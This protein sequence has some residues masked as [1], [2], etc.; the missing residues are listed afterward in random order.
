MRHQAPRPKHRPALQALAALL[1]RWLGFVLFWFARREALPTHEQLSEYEAELKKLI[2]ARAF[3]IFPKLTF[4]AQC[5]RDGSRPLAGFYKQMTR[6]LLPK[7][8]RR[9]RAARAARLHRVLDRVDVY[10]AKLAARLARGLMVMRVRRRIVRTHAPILNAD[11]RAPTPAD[12][13]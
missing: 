3:E 8:Q 9:T 7:L 4:R 5:V 2:F 11:P 10:V 1:R 13:S 6:G 12:T